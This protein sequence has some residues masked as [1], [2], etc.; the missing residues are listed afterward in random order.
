MPDVESMP[1]QQCIHSEIY[2]LRPNRHHNTYRD[3]EDAIQQLLDKEL[4]ISDNYLGMR[5]SERRLH[6]VYNYHVQYFS[7]S[8]TNV[9]VR[10]D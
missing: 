7:C 6:N 3:V 8:L 2:D 10:N 5:L 4:R 1:R 9:N